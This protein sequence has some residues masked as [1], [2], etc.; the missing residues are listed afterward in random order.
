MGNLVYRYAVPTAP[1]AS[2]KLI[3]HPLTL[4][5]IGGCLVAKLIHGG[6]RQH[7]FKALVLGGVLFITGMSIYYLGLPAQSL[8]GGYAQPCSGFL[9]R[10]L[11]M[12]QWPWK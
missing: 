9:T 4:E 12:E 7:G 3:T 10:L 5:F 8:K 6:T 11:F 1:T 2:I